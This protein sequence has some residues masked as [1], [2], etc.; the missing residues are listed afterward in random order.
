MDTL[1]VNATERSLVMNNITHTSL[2]QTLDRNVTSA[3]ANPMGLMGSETSP[4]AV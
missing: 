3:V 1:D 4:R 2:T